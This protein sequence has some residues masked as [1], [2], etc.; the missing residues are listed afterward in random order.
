MTLRNEDA[1]EADW[2]FM[3]S[4]L[5]QYEKKQNVNGED[6]GFPTSECGRTRGE[7]I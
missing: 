3:L 6:D 4:R 1:K 7:L 2:L 5:L